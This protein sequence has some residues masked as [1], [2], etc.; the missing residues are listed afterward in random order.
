MAEKKV[1]LNNW[2]KILRE[3]INHLKSVHVLSFTLRKDECPPISLDNEP[4][5][6]NKKFDI[7]PTAVQKTHFAAPYKN[8]K[9]SNLSNRGLL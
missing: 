2:L 4:I 3:K 9:I 8:E 1:F 5:L 7:W 6:Q